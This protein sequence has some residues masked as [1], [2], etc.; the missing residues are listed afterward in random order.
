MAIARIGSMVV[1][2]ISDRLLSKATTANDAWE[3]LDTDH[4]ATDHFVSEYS[5][6]PLDEFKNRLIDFIE[7]IIDNHTA[8]LFVVKELYENAPKAILNWNII[9]SKVKYRVQNCLTY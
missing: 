7:I 2:S 9:R 5:L 3:L 6:T 1:P 8:T 4:K